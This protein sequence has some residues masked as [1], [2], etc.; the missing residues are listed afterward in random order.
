MGSGEVGT[1]KL[2]SSKIPMD[3]LQLDTMPLRL[4]TKL[5]AELL[6]VTWML[7]LKKGLIL[8][9]DRLLVVRVVAFKRMP[10][11]HYRENENNERVGSSRDRG[12]QTSQN[13]RRAYAESDNRG[14]P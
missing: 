7:N 4:G 9:L 1:S 5:R 3:K 11:N 12:I 14:I 2:R 13:Y 10:L 6:M 8:L